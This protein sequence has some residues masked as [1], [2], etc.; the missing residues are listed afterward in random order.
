MATDLLVKLYDPPDPSPIY[1]KMKQ[2]NVSLVRAMALDRENLLQFVR[3]AF[4]SQSKLWIGECCAAFSSVPSHCFMAAHQGKIIGF[5]CTDATAKGFFG[6]TGV[7]PDFQGLGIGTALL[8]KALYAMREEGYGYA[9]I[10]WV[11]DAL[12]FYEKALN[13]FPIPDSFPSVYDQMAGRC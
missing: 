11:T 2:K 4:P 3:E 5:A 10:G 12:P 7:S 8:Y 13:V 6:P 1:E 9:A